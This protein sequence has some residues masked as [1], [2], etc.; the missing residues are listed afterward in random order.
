M[1]HQKIE[2][3]C[4]TP[5]FCAGA[6]QSRAEIRPTA[7]RGA[8][9]WWFRALGGTAEQEKEVFGG[10]NPVQGSSIQIRVSNFV[11]K[12]TGQLPTVGRGKGQLQPTDPL[13]YILYFAS[14]SGGEGANFGQGPRWQDQGSIGPGST[15]TL[16]IR[17][18]RTLS[19]DAIRLVHE[20]IEAFKHYGSI[21]L[22]VTRGLGA[23]QARD[24]TDETLSSLD[25]LLSSKGFATAHRTKK[26]PDWQ[27]LMKEAGVILKETLRETYGAGGNKKP[28]KATALGNIKPSRQTS[29]VYLRP[30]KIG[31]HLVLSAFEAPHNRVLGEPSRRVHACQ[32]LKEVDL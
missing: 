2:F 25:K 10:S 3:E 19:P 16:H 5:C 17:Q 13:A 6:D 1:I 20:T 12:A 21:G 18:L 14:I 27:S 31:P 15:F 23:L 9:R 4:L 22:R 32:I 11:P 29:A 28:S 26:H 7:I 30:R 24:S 8:L